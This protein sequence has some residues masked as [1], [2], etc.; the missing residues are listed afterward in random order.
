[1]IFKECEFIMLEHNKSKENQKGISLNR[2]I[3]DIYLI[4]R[5]YGLSISLYPLILIFL[6]AMVFNYGI[7]SSP[8]VESDYLIAYSQYKDTEFTEDLFSVLNT[9]AS[10]LREILDINSHIP[11]EIRVYPTLND[12]RTNITELNPRWPQSN[13]FMITGESGSVSL[14]S[15]DSEYAI[16]ND[17]YNEAFVYRNAKVSLAEVYLN[18]KNYNYTKLPSWLSE[19][20]AY[21][22]VA[23]KGDHK[24]IESI[25]ISTITPEPEIMN[26]DLNR[27][28]R[29]TL[30]TDYF[31]MS[32]GR[33]YAFV[34]V[35]YFVQ[36]YDL[37]TVLSWVKNKSFVL[38]DTGYNSYDE[39]YKD[40]EEYIDSNFR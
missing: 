11:I 28:N 10:N 24:Y 8:R 13:T 18:D 1:M 21:Y 15:T 27:T 32:N 6:V 5:K 20:V 31:N 34:F 25:M 2:I 3:N 30:T 16:S 26:I 33:E 12:Y 9:H 39:L 38:E 4:F 40:L 35:E 22:L 7:K 19:G 17:W 29:Y 14:L 23:D 36:M 37:P